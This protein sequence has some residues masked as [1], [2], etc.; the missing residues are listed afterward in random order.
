MKR[1]GS[2]L[3]A[4]VGVSALCLTYALWPRSGRGAA[5][6][7]PGRPLPPEDDLDVLFSAPGVTE[8]RSRAVQIFSE[9]SGTIRVVHVSAGDR[10][11]KGQVVVD[12]DNEIQKA[13]VD[14]AH[15]VLER[16]RADLARMRNGARPEE[17]AIAKAQVDET[18]AALRMAEFEWQRVQQMTKQNAASAK[19]VS[20]AQHTLALTRARSVAARKR[21]EILES[22]PRAEDAARAEAAVHEA[23]AQLATARG[24]A[25]KTSIR[26]PIDGIVLYR[27]REPGEAVFTDKPLPI[28]TVGDRSRLHIR[29]DV[30]EIDIAKVWLGQHVYATASAYDDKRFAG[31]VVHIEPTLGPKNLRTNRPTEKLDTRIQE[32]VVALDDADGVP[33]ELQMVVWFQRTPGPGRAAV[34]A[35]E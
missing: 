32:V 27:F 22:P 2:V 3:S 9:V 14:L 20:D 12:I 33:V 1:A 29:V 18:E 7:A 30:D 21:C 11:V 13:N 10:V 19:E 6:G 17:R 8:P 15:A 25:A 4:V 34:V 16:A 26:S 24:M 31:H 35:G 23:E 5:A 28:L